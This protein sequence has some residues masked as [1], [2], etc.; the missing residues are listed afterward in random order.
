M[1]AL[2]TVVLSTLLLLAA[3]CAKTD[4]GSACHLQDVNGGALTPQP[5]RQYLYLGST[6]CQSFACLSTGTSAGTYCSQPCGGAGG[7]CPNGMTCQELAL[8]QLYLTTIQGRMTPQQFQQMFGQMQS[9]FYCV[10]SQ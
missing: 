1:V 6:D 5:G 2:R 8:D 4:L 9:S 3:A 10:Q 7:S